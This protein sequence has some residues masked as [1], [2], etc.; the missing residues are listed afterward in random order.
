MISTPLLRHFFRAVCGVVF[1]SLAG[2]AT[3]SCQTKIPLP[4][5]ERFTEFHVQ[6]PG[7]HCYPI[8]RTP[9]NGPPVLVLHEL[10]GLSAPPL[11]FSLELG[12]KQWTVYAPALYGEYG[13]SRPVSAL[14]ELKRDPRWKV[15]DPDDSGPILDDVAALIGW[16]SRQ[17]RGQRVIVMG[18]C[19][20]GG[21]P[22]A[23]L[24]R[25]DV[26]AAI[27]CQPA[28][29]LPEGL[30]QTLFKTQPAAAKR[31]LALPVDRVQRSLVAMRR[32]RSKVL[33]GFH[34]LEDPIAPIEKFHT[35]HH[36]LSQH[37]LAGR[38]TPVILVPPGSN[39]N[40]PWWKIH[41]TQ[42]RRGLLKPHNTVTESG[43]EA[44]RLAMRSELYRRMERL[45]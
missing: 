1:A 44:D 20:T 16:I 15:S 22:L 14:R 39:S 12:S 18:N 32:D 24:E 9:R 5:R 38:F 28:M 2:C 37:S 29:P 45:R 23:F 17:H 4:A 6:G 41:P 35:L 40:E 34:Y 19:L 13:D 10:N 36:L 43:S 8:Y 27:L 25:R 3:H 30:W 33:L 42:V 21:F 7:G 31:A 11:D 26:K